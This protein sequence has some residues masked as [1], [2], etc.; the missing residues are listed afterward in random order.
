MER[1]GDTRSGGLNSGKLRVWGLVFAAAGIVGRSILQNRLLGIGTISGQQLLQIMDSGNAMLIAT[2]ALLLEAVETCAVPIFSLLLM[3]G[4]RHT[5]NFKS[6]FFRV[7]GT[8]VLSELPYNLAIGGSLLDTDS[9][10]PVFGLVLGLALLYFYRRYAGG[11]P[12]SVLIKVL[13]TVAALLW[14]MMLKIEYGVCMVAVICVL[15][16]FRRNSLYRNFA[17][18]TAAILCSLI[19]PLFLA[20][21]MGFL[22]VHFYNGEKADGNRLVKYLVY[23]VLLLIIGLLALFIA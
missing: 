21:P 15:W 22:V 1:L 9:R 12:Q 3:E 14:A 10:N 11:S 8:A 7:A 16:A 23:P 5:S 4:F 19:S 2:L 6:Y 18:A 17:G 13:V 20:A